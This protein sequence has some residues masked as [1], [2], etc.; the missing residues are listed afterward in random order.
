MST[1]LD[2]LKKYQEEQENKNK[3]SENSKEEFEKK[4]AE[5]EKQIVKFVLPDKGSVS[6]MIR[7]IAPATEENMMYEYARHNIEIG[8]KNHFY[9]CPRVDGKLCPI[10]DK[11]NGNPPLI[12][13]FYADD[14]DFYYKTKLKTTFTWLV[15]VKSVGVSFDGKI[16]SKKK[17]EITD[18][19][20]SM[21]G[22]VRYL[23]VTKDLNEIIIKTAVGN[24]GMKITPIPIESYEKG[25]DFMISAKKEDVLIN[26]EKRPVTKMTISK[27]VVSSLSKEEILKI[28]SYPRLSPKSFME[29]DRKQVTYEK[30]KEEVLTLYTEYKNAKNGISN[31]IVASVTQTGT[32]LDN[33]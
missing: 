23:T 10:C 7:F 17:A 6:A 4:K 24:A 19:N 11:E 28:N 25:C 12:T 3:Q 32:S 22:S 18:A 31:P 2:Y 20:E 21:I 13:K 9:F 16:D 27:E 5:R 14:I 30:M 1:Q 8:D 15:Y 26:G 33:Y 29:A